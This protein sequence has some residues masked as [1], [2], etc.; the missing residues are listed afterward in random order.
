MEESKKLDYRNKIILAPMVRV[1]TLPMRLLALEYGADIV[2]TEELIDWKLL[3]TKR[4][5]NLALGT[6]DFVDQTDGTVVFRTCALEKGKV[7]VQLGTADHIRALKA[8]KLVENDV[9]GI[10]INMGCPKEFSIKG[11]MGIKLLNSPDKATAILRALTENLSIPV[12]CKIR[13]FP[14]VDESINLIKEFEKCGISAVAIH[15]RYRNE[16]SHHPVHIDTIKKIAE[17]ISIPVIANGGSEEIKKYSDI[18]KFRKNCGASSCMI[19][20]AAQWNCSIFRKEGI[21]PIDEVI[22]TYLKYSVDYDNSPGNSKYC[23]QRVL[24]E[25][26]ESERGRKFLDS[27]TM[28]HLW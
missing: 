24:K 3:K 28:E 23:I 2:Y 7:V 18:N 6:I 21:L 25:L 19:A 10:D 13:I 1:G 9:A 15:G 27:Q 14:N 16:R 17:S 4:R 11:G 22:T 5:E 12:T 8:A 20:R 26:Q